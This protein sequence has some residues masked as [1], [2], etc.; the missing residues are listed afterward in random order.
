[1]TTQETGNIVTTEKYLVMPDEQLTVG[2]NVAL[3]KATSVRWPL[4][5][6]YNCSPSA[7][8]DTPQTLDSNTSN[9]LI[10]SAIV[11]GATILAGAAIILGR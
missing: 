9:S 11:A 2:T 7:P 1:M 10:G 8:I 6:E 5:L 3:F 4:P